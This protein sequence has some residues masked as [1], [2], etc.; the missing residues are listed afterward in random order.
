MRATVAGS[1]VGLGDAAVW[2]AL[3]AHGAFSPK[4]VSAGGPHVARWWKYVE[5]LDAT[6]AIA[7]GFFGAQ[8][9]AGN[10]EI[11]LPD[12]VDGEVVT[13]FPPEPSGQ[14]HIGHVKACLLNAYFAKRYNGKMLLRFDDTNPSKE[15]GEHEEA[16][17]ADLK[18]L[19][20]TPSSVSHTSDHFEAILKIQTQMIADGLAYVDPSKAEE[21]QAGRMAKKDSPYRTATID[22]NLRLWK[23]MQKGS[24]EGLKCCVRAKIDMQSNNGALRDPATFRCNLTPHH[25]TKEKYK[26]YP[27][28]DLACPIVDALEGVTHA[29]R[30]RQYSDRDAQYEW[31]LTNLKLRKVHL[32]GFSRINFV[33]TLL[34]KRKLQWL[35]DQGLAD[36]WD[37]PRFPT[38]EGILR[39]GMTVPGLKAFILSMGASKNTNL[40]EWDK[41]WAFNKAE[42]DPAAHRYT[43]LLKTGLV[44][45]TLGA[46]APAAPYAQSMFCHPKD[47]TVGKKIR[48]FAPTV[49][50]QADDAAAVAEGE[51]VTLMSW[52]NAIVKKVHKGAG[53]AVVSIDAD[54]HLAGDV[55]KTKKKLT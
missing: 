15:K 9:D 21:Q 45:V 33:K 24:E 53:G 1:S 44:P 10:M 16:I 39:R 12:A 19:D 34:S 11:N 31:F 23:E 17:L 47:Q 35:I 36:G 26:V 49:L 27:T 22:E 6:A 48:M 55:K 40:M 46:G 14:L 7:Q 18:R 37:D 32:W 42:V 54:L 29:L 20:I 4:L 8:K 52:G 5:S 41:I 30:D 13:R 38:V 25:Q 43:A 28:Y 2:V 3:R 50:L 51:E